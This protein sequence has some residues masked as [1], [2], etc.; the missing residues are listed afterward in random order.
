[1][2]DSRINAK[3]VQFVVDHLANILARTAKP[4]A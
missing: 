2:I 4:I 1:M 3:G